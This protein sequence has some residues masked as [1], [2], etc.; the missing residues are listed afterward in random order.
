[1]LNDHLS[2]EIICRQMLMS[3]G[4]GRISVLRRIIMI[5]EGGVFSRRYSRIFPELIFCENPR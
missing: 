4:S 2:V 1:M 5:L 3:A